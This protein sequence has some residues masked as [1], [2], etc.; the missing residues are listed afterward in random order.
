MFA[1]NVVGS[2]DHPAGDH[3]RIKPVTYLSTVA[4]AMTV[5]PQS[6]EEDDDIRTISPVRAVNAP[7]AS[8]YANSKWAG[9]RS[10]CAR[11]TICATCR[12]RCSAP[13]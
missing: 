11:H 1:P 2:G 5:D 13:T 6:F 12:S 3:H 8:G 7:Y 4:V 10:C 9:E